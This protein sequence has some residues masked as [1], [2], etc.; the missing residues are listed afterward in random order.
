LEGRVSR[1][2]KEKLNGKGKVKKSTRSME[3]ETK[4][5]RNLQ[6]KKGKERKRERERGKLVPSSTGRP[7]IFYLL[8]L[9]DTSNRY[10]RASSS[11]LFPVSYLR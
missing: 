4:S 6:R 11:R 1:K 8:P 5:A 3:M 2:G 7:R 9:S 10:L